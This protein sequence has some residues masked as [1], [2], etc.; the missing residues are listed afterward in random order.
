MKKYAALL[1]V[2]FICL[3]IVFSIHIGSK[4]SQRI[5]LDVTEESLYT[6]SDGTKKVLGSIS[7]PMKIKLYYSKTAANKGTEGLRAFNNYFLYVKDLLAEFVAYSRNNLSLEVIDPRPD[8]KEEQ[9]ALTAGLR[10]YDLTETEKYFFGLVIENDDGRKKIIEFFD[11]KKQERIEYEIIKLIYSTINPRKKIIGVYSSL[12]VLKKDL[13]PYMAQMMR[14]QGK[15]VESSWLFMGLLKELYTVKSIE[16]KAFSLKGLDILVLI[17]PKEITDKNLFEIDQFLLKGG[18]LAIFVDPHSLADRSAKKGIVSTQGGGA[19][20]TLNRLMKTWGVEMNAGEFAGDKYLSGI[21]RTHPQS[22]PSRLLQVINCSQICSSLYK[23]QISAGLNRAVF[24][25]PGALKIIE[26]K[27]GLMHYPIVG[28][29]D[30]GNIYK[31][32]PYELANSRAL[33]EKFKEGTRPVLMGLKLVGKF[34]SSFPQGI[35]VEDVKSKKKKKKKLTGLTLSQRESAVVVFS[36]VDFITDRFSFQKSM[37][38]PAPANDNSTLAFNA[39]ESLVGSKDLMKI[40]SR[41][42]FNR[43]FDVIDQIEFKAK[44]NT[45]KKVAQIQG[46]IRRYRTEIQKLGSFANQGN[47]QLIRSEGL[48][49][50]K[51]LTKKIASLKGELRDVRREGREKVEIIGKRLQYLNTL[52]I[53][54][55]LIIIGT[56]VNL[57]PYRKKL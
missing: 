20:S 24:V 44:N 45:A 6:L 10:K 37:F 51:E 29:T 21:G 7:R 23:E 50:R 35:D 27:K 41:G 52:L 53:P 30:K 55:L 26:K 12:P 15:E 39:I 4:M 43:S 3:I 25:F 38:G 33:M 42:K 34:Q 32:A 28:T 56:I 16:E 5:K 18:K 8:T 14:F 36:D 49:K 47:L 9:D 19:G 2:L 54:L 11:P 46:S 1:D 31:A 17:H 22:P 40:R 57:T 48:R 13:N